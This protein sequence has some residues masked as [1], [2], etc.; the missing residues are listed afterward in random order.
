MFLWPG[1]R[2]RR[3][4]GGHSQ[5]LGWAVVRNPHP[6]QGGREEKRGTDSRGALGL[7]FLGGAQESSDA[8]KPT[9]ARSMAVDVEATCG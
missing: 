7:A 6:R 4:R 9:P 1:E 8:R 2:N 3:W 5:I